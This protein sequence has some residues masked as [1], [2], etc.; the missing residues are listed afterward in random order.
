MPTRAPWYEPEVPLDDGKRDDRQAREAAIAAI[1]ERGRG[2]RKAAPRWMW[3]AALVVGGIAAIGFAIAMLSD[4]APAAGRS[5][6][7]AVEHSGLGSG[8]VLGAAIGIVIGFAI[9]RQRRSHS[10]RNNP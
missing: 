2:V 5:A 8:L 6:P 7:R 10:S 4:D 3:I 9:A 1:A